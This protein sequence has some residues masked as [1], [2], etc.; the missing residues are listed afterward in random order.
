MLFDTSATV[1]SRNENVIASRPV[2]KAQKLLVF[3][4]H[5]SVKP[6]VQFK[7]VILA[8]VILDY[9]FLKCMQIYGLSPSIPASHPIKGRHITV[10]SQ[11]MDDIWHLVSG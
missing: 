11:S 7:S 1:A 10:Y 3:N 9:Y 5:A 6:N 8:L 4:D 2:K